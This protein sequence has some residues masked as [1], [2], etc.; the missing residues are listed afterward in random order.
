MSGV[1][2]RVARALAAVQ[3]R[4]E[5]AVLWTQLGLALSASGQHA[6]AARAFEQAS[7]RAPAPNTTVRWFQAALAAGDLA[8]ARRVLEQTPAR[9]PQPVAAWRALAEAASARRLPVAAAHAWSQAVAAAP[10]D[11]ELRILA[12]GA[13]GAAGQ[14]IAGLAHLDH[15]AGLDPDNPD[16]WANLSVLADQCGAPERAREAARR[17]REL[18][19]QDPHA[20]LVLARQARR[21]GDPAGAL[22][23]LAGDAFATGGLRCAARGW[24][25]RGRALD[26]LGDPAGAFAAF[27]EMNRIAERRPE[28]DT[29]GMARWRQRLGSTTAAVPALQAAAAAPWTPPDDGPP[30]VFVCG[31]PRSGTTLLA[32]ILG[33]HPDLVA[34]DE[35]PALDVVVAQSGRLLGRPG[36]YPG[37]VLPVLGEPAVRATLRAAYRQAFRLHRPQLSPADRVVDKMP[38]NLL[39]LPLLAALFPDARVVCI[40]RDPRD[41]ALSCFMQDFVHNEAMGHMTSLEAIAAVQAESLDCFLAARAQPGLPLRELWYEDLVAAPEAVLRPLIDWLGLPWRPELLDGQ[42]RTAGHHIT[43]PSFDRVGQAIDTSAVARW[44]RYAEQLA[45]VRETLL[46]TVD[47]LA[48]ASPR[49]LALTSHSQ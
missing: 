15:A 16:V 13:A 44:E 38:F 26:A 37:S 24:G 21:S 11:I 18:R 46:A 40:H 25:E 47:R 29:A 17:A 39:H 5:R 12:A 7:A 43:T 3:A 49:L 14:G 4:P 23:L 30:P 1:S 35:T 19:P 22:A 32:S 45:P 48:T 2:E 42:R 9:V 41:T 28:R 36:P 6:P 10:D 33:A 27:A 34:T 20:V 31:F 8:Q